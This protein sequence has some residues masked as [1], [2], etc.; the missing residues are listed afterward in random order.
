[1]V[2]AQGI[3][4]SRGPK[5]GRGRLLVHVLSHSAAAPFGSRV[6]GMILSGALDDGIAGL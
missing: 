5:G 1:M 6:I 2:T 4:L 3:R